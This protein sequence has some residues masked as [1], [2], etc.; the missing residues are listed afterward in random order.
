MKIMLMLCVFLT[1]KSCFPKQRRKL[2]KI[3]ILNHF[4]R[5]GVIRMIHDI[6]SKGEKFSSII[7]GFF[8]DLFGDLFAAVAMDEISFSAR[9][10]DLRVFCLRDLVV[11]KFFGF[12]RWKCVFSFVK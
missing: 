11:F 4:P 7:E 9:L 10:E 12:V 8:L 3:L 6:V 5:K 1:L 2:L